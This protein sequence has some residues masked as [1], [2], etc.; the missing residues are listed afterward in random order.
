M[1]RLFI[2]GQEVVLPEQFE[3]ELITENPYFTR[4]GEYTYDIDI[5]L[6]VPQ[7]RQIYKNIQRSDVTTKINNRKAV[8]SAGAYEL[9]TG[10]EVV[11]SI[12]DDT[13][14]IQ[15]VAGNSQ[16]NYDGNQKIRDIVLDSVNYDKSMAA[17]S[18]LGT[19]HNYN[20][21]YTPVV[22][23]DN[24]SIST[25][26]NRV[27]M[28][29]EA[30]PDFA[31]GSKLIPQYY[32]LYI[33]ENLLSKLGLTKSLN[34]L[35]NN[36]LWQRVFIVNS[37]ENLQAQEVLPD[38]TVNEFIEQIELFMNCIIEVDKRTGC[39][40]IYDINNYFK[41]TDN[42]YIDEVVDSL[43]K[44]YDTDTNYSFTYEYV[45]YD[46]PN[47]EAYNYMKLRDGIRG[48][49]GEYYI[50]SSEDM[51]GNELEELNKKT[52]ILY[53]YQ[54]GI[55]LVVIKLQNPNTSSEFYTM[56]IV[57]RFRDIGDSDNG[58]KTSFSIVPAE[59]GIVSVWDYET[60]IGNQCCAVKQVTSYETEEKDI[61]INDLINGN[62][63]TNSVIPDKLYVG[64]YFGLQKVKTYDPFGE[65]Y[66]TKYGYPNSSPDNFFINEYSNY[67]VGI[68]NKLPN[69]TLA[70]HGKY[71]LYENVYKNK[72]QIDTTVEYKFK[73]ITNMIYELNR[74]FVIRNKR[75]YC[76]E[77]RYK[78]TPEGM[79]KIAEGVFYLAE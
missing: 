50:P 11:L 44:T 57:D 42:I 75:Y 69:Y 14:K 39:Y 48:S 18:L 23:H 52:Y 27:E 36:E 68:I 61:S 41:S 63:E 65:V 17:N 8:I 73:F 38:W 46:F 6:K 66:E 72:R 25:D 47:A 19:C 74:I 58:N 64:I 3:L 59:T 53:S 60:G 26:V 55:D 28:R 9:I 10:I 45:S 62:I 76:K 71:G 12:D 24:Y 35:E 1:T 40:S 43:E 33:V 5:D 67:Y 77:I 7:N 30:Q 56:R 2:D 29:G 34:E 22:R 79:D 70:L 51:N 21:V 54:Y 20:A 4:T 32:L 78:I 15:I 37:R 31:E 13:A 49:V 16:L